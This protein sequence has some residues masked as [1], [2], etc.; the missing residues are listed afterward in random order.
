MNSKE[1]RKK[2]N[3][4]LLDRMKNPEDSLTN[5]LKQEDI[6]FPIRKK[7]EKDKKEL[8]RIFKDEN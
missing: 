3:Q 4:E 7:I 6:F 5:G 1:L 2:R 8:K